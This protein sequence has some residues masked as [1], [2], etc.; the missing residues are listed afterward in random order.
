MS[1]STATSSYWDFVD[2]AESAP[3][4]LELSSRAFLGDKMVRELTEGPEIDFGNA[5]IDFKSTFWDF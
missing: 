5:K 3:A 1:A 2:E 4:I